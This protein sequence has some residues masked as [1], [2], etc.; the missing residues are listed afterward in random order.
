MAIEEGG[1]EIVGN[2]LWQ[3][4]EGEMRRKLLSKSSTYMQVPLVKVREG[5]GTQV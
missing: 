5:G 1:A 3:H 4:K 2:L